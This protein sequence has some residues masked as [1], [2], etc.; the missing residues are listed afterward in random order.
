MSNF[1]FFC[2]SCGQ[3]V[4]CDAGYALRRVNCPACR[5]LIQVPPAQPAMAA[6]PPIAPP[7]LCQPTPVPS[8]PLGATPA[9]IRSPVKTSGLAVASLCCSLGTLV[10]GP[11]GFVPGIICG[12][13]AKSQIKR[14]LGLGGSGM[15]TA[16][17]A[18]GYGF[19]V[20]SVIGVVVLASFF[21]VGARQLQKATSN[22]QNSTSQ[23]SPPVTAGE[24]S[25][26]RIAKS[27]EGTTLAGKIHGQDF[28]CE[29][30]KLENGILTLRQGKDF[31]ADREV[32]IF[33][34]PKPG[35]S[36]EEKT[37]DIG[38]NNNGT[39]PHVWLKWKEPGKNLPEQKAYT[40][41]YTMRLEFGTITDG[42]LP[43][44][45]RVSLPDAEQSFAEGTFQA[46][47][48]TAPKKK[49]PKPAP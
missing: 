33:L 35:E 44:K 42:M 34:F 45:I 32:M 16:G 27:A 49:T 48:G 23:S 25:P 37:F 9:A 12:H 28:V 20:L 41:G 8:G 24:A 14:S 6:P 3:H 7:S 10:V 30:A 13:M 2:P 39:T 1:K 40:S 17:L 5:Q 47:T 15:A 21:V 22:P 31:F 18:V 29:K 43:G 36:L 4:E 26:D 46:E 11:F 19:L 38:K